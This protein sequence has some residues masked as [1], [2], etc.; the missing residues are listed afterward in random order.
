MLR[1]GC[2]ELGSGRDDGDGRWGGSS[3]RFSPWDRGRRWRRGSV[4]ELG[5][6]K[7]KHVEMLVLRYDRASARSRPKVI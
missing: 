7:S 6:L 2:G 5:M 4:N 3:G 1:M